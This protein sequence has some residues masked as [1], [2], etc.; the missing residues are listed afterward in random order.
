[1]LGHSST[2]PVTLDEMISFTGAVARSTSRAMVIG[3]LPFGSYQQGPAQAVATTA[4][5]VKE[6]GAQAVKLEGGRR[7]APQIRA[8]VDAGVPVCGHVGLT[9]QSELSLGLRV[10]G[11]GDSGDEVLADALAV[12]EAGAF[13]VVLEALPAELAMRIT[14]ELTIP[15]VGIGAG[16]DC[17]AQVLVWTDMAGL[18]ERSPKF[19]KRYADLRTALSE[20]ATAFADEVRGGQFPDADT[21]YS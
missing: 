11:R 7:C 19:V 3:D 2:L 14:G 4:R 12:Q 15:T 9:P 5:F 1:V 21:S 13:A 10:Q 18:T 8:I 20:A 17:D 6:A 16:V